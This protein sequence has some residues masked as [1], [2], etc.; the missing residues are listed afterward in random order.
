MLAAVIIGT[1]LGLALAAAIIRLG[2]IAV[3][4]PDDQPL[5]SA[6]LEAWFCANCSR[7]AVGVRCPSCG[8]VLPEEEP[9]PAPPRVDDDTGEFT[10]LVV[11][12][13][14]GSD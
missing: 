8:W 7:P 4:D 10:A 14:G 13:P 5:T 12:P 1:A 6:P 2:S 3:P 9:K 11:D